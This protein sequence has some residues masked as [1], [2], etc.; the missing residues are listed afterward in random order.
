MAR[1]NAL[2]FY[3]MLSPSERAKLHEWM[4]TK[5]PNEIIADLAKKDKRK[6]N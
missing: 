5:K 1:R 2:K 4:K 6:K 3:K